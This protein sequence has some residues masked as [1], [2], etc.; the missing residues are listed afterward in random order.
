MNCPECKSELEEDADLCLECGEPIGNSVAARVARADNKQ[1]RL[2]FERDG[3]TRRMPSAAL[4]P[5]KPRPSA[6]KTTL[7]IPI[8]AEPLIAT[9]EPSVP[10][11]CSGCGALGHGDR[12]SD[13]GALL[14]Q[15]E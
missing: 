10:V 14:R 5:P 15:S 12:C 13:C 7:K 11:R 6:S 3:K 2:E 1:A 8:S 9:D 4:P